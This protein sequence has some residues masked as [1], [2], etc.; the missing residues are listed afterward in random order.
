[1]RL[2]KSLVS[3][4]LVGGAIAATITVVSCGRTVAPKSELKDYQEFSL[5]QRLDDFNYITGIFD[6]YYA[7]LEYKEQRFG[8]NWTNLK[9]E[10]LK[11]I[12]ADGLSRTEFAKIMQELV[13][14]VKDAHTSASFLRD[15]LSEGMEIKIATLGFSTTREIKDGKNIAKVSSVYQKFFSSRDEAPVKAGDILV[16]L[17]G[18]DIDAVVKE[19]LIK[20]RDLGQS[21]S[22]LTMSYGMGLTNRWN[23]FNPELPSGEVVAKIK[24][25]DTV[26]DVKLNWVKASLSDL[27]VN[28]ESGSD[29]KTKSIRQIVDVRQDGTF[30][31]QERKT[32]PFLPGSL[33]PASDNVKSLKM[34]LAY[35]NEVAM[36][37]L[38]GSVPGEDYP[39]SSTDIEAEGLKFKLINSE[40][41]LLA[42]YRVEDFVFSRFLCGTPVEISEG[43]SVATCKAL[44]GE[45]YA[46]A[47]VK[48][49]ALGV[50]ALVLDLRSNGGGFLDA[51]YEL[52][53]AFFKSS[54]ELNKASLRLNEE[55]VGDMRYAANSEYVPVAVRDAYAQTVK[56]LE[57]DIAANKK[58]SSPVSIMGLNAAPGVETAWEGK[59]YVIV[60]EMCASMCDIFSTL[61]QDHKRATILG[62]QSMGAGG[63][64][65]GF[66]PSPHMKMAVSQTASV[67]YRLD[68]SIIENEGVKPDSA[69][70]VTVGDDF[71]S[72]VL[73]TVTREL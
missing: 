25:G 46:K 24:R 51:G 57:A 53:R 21:E 2:A 16:S 29:N 9:S 22:N 68:G 48:L 39:A 55:W 13:A 38:L 20:Y 72:K 70:E 35:Q 15:A 56:T 10:Y 44:T 41:G 59:T 37:K 18:R 50:K 61:M 30:I 27:I 69:M 7:M 23:I 1:M 63:N 40:K 60:D 17:N 19:D 64:V 65:I 45:D 33:L 43:F 28:Q 6:E 54:F 32:G 62:K 49:K 34:R 47:F 4:V 5:Q 73:A 26:F 12:S 11:R 36:S 58:L 66:A 3:S 67:M 14:Q 31:V 8:F 71:W 52:M 42:S